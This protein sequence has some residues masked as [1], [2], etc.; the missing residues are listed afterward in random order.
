[1][2]LLDAIAGVLGLGGSGGGG[3]LG[4]PTSFDIK[5]NQVKDVEIEHVKDVEI[6]R[7]KDVEIDR[8]QRI[9]PMAAHIKE[10]NNIDPLTIDSFNI[11]EFKNI[12]PIRIQQFNVTNLPNVNVTLRQLPQVDMNIRTLPP[13]S[14]G[15]NQDFVMPSNYTVRMQLLGFE[16][17]RIGLS[18]E[19][20][21]VP[22]DKARR[23][24]ARTLNMSAPQPAAAGNPAI[25]S[26]RSEQ[27]VVSEPCGYG[28]NQNR[29]N[30]SCQGSSPASGLSIGF[31]AMGFNLSR[32]AN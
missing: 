16:V 9:A 1:M 29:H 23:E 14:V 8:I 5:I 28:H 6:E 25:P 12:D 22:R 15:L 24:Q 32:A 26:K 11:T 19:T 4:I 3:L 20:R 18:G 30:S 21:V 13:L 2:D 10:I 31:P 27:T 17:M 7:V